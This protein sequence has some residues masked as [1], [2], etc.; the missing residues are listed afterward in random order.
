MAVC[1]VC[2]RK[3]SGSL[4]FCKVHYQEYEGD[5]RDKKPW[6]KVL[7]NE[8]QRERR[9]KERELNDVSLDSLMDRAYR[10][11]DKW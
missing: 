11:H 8:V 7:K 3:T 1:V 10:D 9:R 2:E 5:I 6:V 4:N